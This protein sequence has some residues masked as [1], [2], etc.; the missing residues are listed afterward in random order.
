MVI[1]A[2][3]AIAASP[4]APCSFNG[5]SAYMPPYYGWFSLS[6]TSFPLLAELFL[7]LIIRVFS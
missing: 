7:T 5:Y 4:C 3:P 2:S 1:A 6:I